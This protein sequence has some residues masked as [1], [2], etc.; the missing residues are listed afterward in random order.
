MRPAPAPPRPSPRG[1]PRGAPAPS[2]NTSGPAWASSASPSARGIPRPSIAARRSASIVR[3]GKRARPS[4]SA[5][6]RSRCAPAGTISVSSP[7]CQGLARVDHAPRQDQVQRPSQPDDARQPL[8]AAVDQRHAPAPLR[9]SR[10]SSP[11]WR[12]AGR[13]TAPAPA[14]PPGRTRRSPRSSAWRASACVNP[15]GPSADISLPAIVSVA[16]RSAPAQNDTPPAPVSTITRASSSASNRRYASCSLAAV[17]PS[18]ALRRCWRSIVITAA[19]P[20]RS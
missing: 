13:T 16:F 5:S 18:T 9:D 6:A 8:G 11:R 19:A 15:I 12:S 10:A 4:A 2:A 7:I 20:S 3:C 17:S 14:R 1:E